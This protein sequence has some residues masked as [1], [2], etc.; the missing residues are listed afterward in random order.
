MI[1]RATWYLAIMAIA[2]ATA[3]LQLDRQ[4]A[5]SPDLAVLV[6][7][8]FRS[9]SQARVAADSLSAN[10]AALAL[11]EAEKLV[12]R[13]PIPA[14]SLRLLALAQYQAGQLA[15]GSLSIQHAA[16]RGWRD[17]MAQ[18]AM[19]RLA[20]AAGDNAEAARRYTALLAR[21]ETPDAL[22]EDLG[23]EIFA[24]DDGTAIDTVA[25]IVSGSDRWIDLFLRRGARVMPASAF[26]EVVVKSI[27]KGA[28]IDCA[29][30]RGLAAAMEQRDRAAAS[31]LA[32]SVSECAV[33][34]GP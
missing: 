24:R 33:R 2:V 11:E 15:E 4:T 34:I 1:A 12:L 7:E 32:M 28:V 3:F 13:R 17:R 27:A 29:T 8:P 26:S 23:G 22:L 9:V 20:L 19:A 18:E 14:Q 6:P 5:V 16:R 30:I 10:D 21:Q 25:D 31:R